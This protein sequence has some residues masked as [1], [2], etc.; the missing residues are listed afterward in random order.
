MLSNSTRVAGIYVIRLSDTHYYGGRS[1]D[2]IGRW[3]GHLRSLRDG[4]H[5]NRRMQAVFDIH[6]RFEP[7]IVCLWWAR[8]E[9]LRALEQGWLNDNFRKPGCV[10]LTH[11]SD[12]GG[13]EWT[14]ASREKR[15]ALLEANPELK[16]RLMAVLD[17]NRPTA[18]KLA[19]EARKSPAAR[20]NFL[21]AQKA[22]RGVPQ[23]PECV[24]KRAESHRGRKNTPE[25]LRKMSESAKIRAGMHPT[26]HGQQTRELISSQQRGRVWVN[27]GAI[28]RRV[29]PDEA[30]IL[31]TQ[32]WR[33]CR[34]PFAT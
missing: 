9:D 17:K 3:K 27:D 21:K 15:K 2:C 8:G 34:L 24:A 7:E 30:L 14:E 26:V 13:C 18:L 29:W 1:V 11:T 28:N 25:T 12:G 20:E 16:A 32:G 6:G 5:E 33:S 10:N 19:L 4:T 23:K 31:L 22:R